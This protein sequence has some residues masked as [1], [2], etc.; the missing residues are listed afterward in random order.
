MYVL[1]KTLRVR[2]LILC[3]FTLLRQR[4]FNNLK[5]D[6]IFVDFPETRQSSKN[7]PDFS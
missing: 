6:E 3:N 1:M 7:E 5:L 4:V 2:N